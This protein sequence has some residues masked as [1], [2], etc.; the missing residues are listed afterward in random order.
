MSALP[1]HRLRPAGSQ[2]YGISN[3]Y[4]YDGTIASITYPSGR[5]VSYQYDGMGHNTQVW[6]TDAAS[7]QTLYYASQ[8]TYMPDGQLAGVLLGATDSGCSAGV[9]GFFSYNQRLQPRH[10]LYTANAGPFSDASLGCNANAGDIMHRQYSFVDP[11]WNNGNNGNVSSIQNC[12]DSDRGQSFSYDG[13]DRIKAMASSANSGPK[14]YGEA[15]TIDAWGNLTGINPNGKDY[16]EYPETTWSGVTATNRNQLANSNAAA[17]SWITYDPAGTGNETVDMVG[18]QYSYDAE[19]RIATVNYEGVT[20]YVY[21]GDGQR[22]VKNGGGGGGRVYW[23]GVGGEILAESDL[24][25]NI[26]SEYVYFNGKRLARTDNPTDPATAQLRYYFSDHLGSTSMVTDEMFATVL[27]DN[28]YYPYG[29]VAY[30]SVADDL[31]NH[32]FFTGK[33]RDPE[34]GNDYFGARYY[35]SGMGRFMRPDEPFVDQETT[36][37]QSWNLYSYVRN[38]PINDSDPSGNACVQASSG[39]YQ[40]DGGAGESCA[41][42]DQNI[43]NYID[44]GRASVTVTDSVPPQPIFAKA[45]FNPAN[46]RAPLAFQGFVNLVLNGDVRRGVPQLAVGLLPSALGSF[47]AARMAGP[48]VASEL[49]G[50]A[51]A[52]PAEVNTGTTAVYQSANAEGDVQYVGMTNDLARRA[53]EHAGKFAIEEIPGLSNLSRSDAR[54]VE[55]VLIETHGVASDGGMLLNRINSIAATNPSYSAQIQRGIQILRQVGYPGF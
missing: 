30:Q 6:K 17:G 41:Q 52:T 13:L 10:M 47:A 34:T 48:A 31:N 55:Q 20:S 29:G 22:V 50:A 18:R 3:T 11:N 49:A 7:G 35:G 38:N 28:D 21:D 9:N 16:T 54:A 25:G 4:N 15:Y 37:P 43:Q 39:G 19:N 40:D 36:D 5:L 53:S 23:Q 51:N 14:S 46:D 42:V 24:L 32:F 45:D 12:L 33:E 2:A 26:T 44:Q 8:A 27:E 1:L